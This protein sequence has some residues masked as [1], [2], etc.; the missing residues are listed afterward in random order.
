MRVAE[1]R[2]GILNR[3]GDENGRRDDQEEEQDA[4]HM[5][6]DFTMTFDDACQRTRLGVFYRSRTAQTQRDADS[7]EGDRLTRISIDWLTT[8]TKA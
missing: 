1:T 6:R 2:L 3:L 4:P 8:R 5:G 7:T